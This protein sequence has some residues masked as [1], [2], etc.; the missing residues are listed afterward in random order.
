MRLSASVCYTEDEW[1][2]FDMNSQ[3]HSFS[4]PNG[5]IQRVQLVR[6]DSWEELHDLAP[7]ASDKAL[8]CFSEVYRKFLVPAA[9]W[10]FGSLV[11][12]RLP[13]GAEVPYSIDDS[14]YGSV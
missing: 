8:D 9:P 1:Q 13:E 12:F 2:V 11:L 3:I 5:E 6:L 7:A 10:V 4:Y 14:R